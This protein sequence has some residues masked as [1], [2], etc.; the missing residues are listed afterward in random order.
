M[1]GGFKLDNRPIG[2]F[3]SGLGGLTAV[4]ELMHQLPREKIVYFGDTGRV[5]YGTRSN[6][7]II[8]Y[9][10]QNIRFLLKF[11]IKLIIIACGTASSV[12]LEIA[13]KKFDVPII[14]VVH[15]SS[16]QALKVSKNKK[17]GIIGTQS[18]INSNAY[19]NKIIR[20]NADAKTYSNACPLFVPLVENGYIDH[21]VTY[22]IAEEYLEP[23]KQ[24]NIDTLILGCTHYSLLKKVIEKIMGPEVKLIDS[25]VETARY[26][27]KFLQ[28]KEMLTGKDIEQP[29]YQYFV[30]D[31]IQ[32]FSRLASFFLQRPIGDSIE[33]IDIEQY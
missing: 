1:I 10:L 4:K 7:T 25:G 8:K 11:D 32:N 5:P 27:K 18:T 13:Q 26:A 17:I 21:Q 31:D 29:Q 22:L 12:A 20:I 3:D 6:E 23:L 19:S 30:S 2:V 24:E 33:K 16:I 9:V 14:G 15:P 28:E